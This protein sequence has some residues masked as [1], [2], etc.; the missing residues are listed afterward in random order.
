MS[1]QIPSVSNPMVGGDFLLSNASSISQSTLDALAKLSGLSSFATFSSFQQLTLLTTDQIAALISSIEVLISNEQSIISQNQGTVQQLRIA[2]D[3][4]VTG[5]QA[6]YESTVDAYSTAV[7]LYHTEVDRQHSTESTISAMTGVLCTLMVEDGEDLSSIR[8]YQAEYSTLMRQIQGNEDLLNSQIIGYNSLSSIYGDY[9]Q[10]YEVLLSTFAVEM[11]PSTLMGIS[12]NMVRYIGL[13][14]ELYP[15]I[16]STLNSISSLSFYSTTYAGDIS[17]YNATYR[18]YSSLEQQTLEAINLLVAERGILTGRIT[19]YSQDLWSLSQSSITEFGTLRSQTATF[20]SKKRLQI[21]NQLLSFRLSVQEW[22][23]FVGFLVSQLTIHS[24]NLYGGINTLG[25]QIA[26]IQLSDPVTVAQLTAQQSE[27][28][29]ERGKIEDIVRIL[30]RLDT[31]NV[32]S[33]TSL[34]QLCDNEVAERTAFMDKRIELTSMEINVLE[35]AT[36]KEEYRQS[37]QAAKAD[38]EN[39][40]VTNIN[41]NMG[42]RWVDFDALF[43]IILPQIT[44]IQNLTT[45]ALSYSQPVRPVNPGT[46]FYLNPSEFQIL[47]FLQY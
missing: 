47:E 15:Y 13:Q 4:P 23:S 24:T 8:G 17:T 9:I 25:I 43:T 36:R 38:M 12:T 37:Y 34:G 39:V 5:Y 42:R 22:K 2:I 29:T 11:N 26:Q 10:N 7:R 33:F 14:N 27:Y 44:A 3:T 16:Q 31:Q 41:T 21:Q 19:R 40:R 32:P 18:Y 1:N 28:T 35:N 45:A 6:R 46:P 20:Y 30:N